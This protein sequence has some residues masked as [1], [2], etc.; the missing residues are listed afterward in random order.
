MINK[1]SHYGHNLLS[2]SPTDPEGKRMPRE[3][4]PPSR[5][6]T[7]DGLAPH[8]A[9]RVA[10]PQRGRGRPSRGI[11]PVTP[12]RPSR[13]ASGRNVNESIVIG[14]DD[15]SDVEI[16]EPPKSVKRKRDEDKDPDW[17]SAKKVRY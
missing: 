2:N 3:I 4:K 17:G 10:T 11:S 5:Y 1:L 6:V 9:R 13:V 7:E 12:A 16:V 14:D 8:L 15:D